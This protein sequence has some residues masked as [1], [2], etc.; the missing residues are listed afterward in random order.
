MKNMLKNLIAAEST[1]EK[2]ELAAAKI[3]SAE[4]AKSSIDSSITA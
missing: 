2:G 3:I 4:F 1:A